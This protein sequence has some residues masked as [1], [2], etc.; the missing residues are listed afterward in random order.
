MKIHFLNHREWGIDEKAFSPFIL[1]LKKTIRV[2]EGDFNVVFVND[3]YIRQ[4]NKAYRGKNK[5]TDVLSFNYND[6]VEGLAGEIYISVDT[7]KR[8]A[9]D[10]RH[11]L[12][13]EL[14]KL[15][16]HGFLHIHGY[17]HE[18]DADYKR[19]HSVECEVLGE[20]VT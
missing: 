8:Q 13:S 14:N 5:P 18:K 1:K 9:K 12:Q 19:M 15:F 11:P 17:D 2:H 10:F 20:D 16:V 6:D 4:L 7:A 3:A